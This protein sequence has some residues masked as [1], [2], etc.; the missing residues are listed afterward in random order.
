MEAE[1]VDPALRLQQ[2]LDF[3]FRSLDRR[4]R[5][6]LEIRQYLESKRVEAATIDEAVAELARQGYLDDA[7]FASQFADDKRRLEQWGADRIERRLVARGISREVARAAL[8]DCDRESELD[9]ALGVLR[10]RF[11][12][13]PCDARGHRSAYGVLVRKGYDPE[14]ASDALRAYARLVD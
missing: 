5:T 4:A 8:A 14:V 1:R 6:V 7:R 3:A 10:R 9:G 2:A 11:P 12:S 13:P